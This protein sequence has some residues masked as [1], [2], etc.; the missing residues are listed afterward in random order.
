MS[1]K[2]ERTVMLKQRQWDFLREKA[3]QHGLADEAKAL[4]CLVDY[5]IDRGEEVDEDIFKTIRCLNC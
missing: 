1:D 5:A 2:V 4:R 3:Q